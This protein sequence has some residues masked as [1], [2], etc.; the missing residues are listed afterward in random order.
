M[1]VMVFSFVLVVRLRGQMRVT[2]SVTFERRTVEPAM[3]RFRKW[4]RYTLAGT[5]RGHSGSERLRDAGR[6]R[7]LST[8]QHVSSTIAVK[9]A[10]AKASPSSNVVGVKLDSGFPKTSL[11]GYSC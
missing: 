2:V 8:H 6:R 10:T 1:G 9:S 4:K 5:R 3:R 7:L 11:A